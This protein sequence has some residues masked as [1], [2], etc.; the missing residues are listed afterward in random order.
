VLVWILNHRIWPFC[1][2]RA[3]QRN[4]KSTG[5]L[6]FETHRLRP[7]LVL[8]LKFNSF[9]AAVEDF[10]KIIPDPRYRRDLAQ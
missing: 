4:C 9:V 10:F 3:S 5:A 1:K 8:D 6:Y 7:Y 2:S